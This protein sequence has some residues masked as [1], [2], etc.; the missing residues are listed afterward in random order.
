MAERRYGTGND[1]DP[2]GPRRGLSDYQRRDLM[3]QG[4]D[5]VASI[6]S[7]AG[8]GTVAFQQGPQIL[9]GLAG[10][11]GGGAGEPTTVHLTIFVP[12]R[13]RRFAEELHV[14]CRFQHGWKG[15]TGE[16]AELLDHAD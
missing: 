5:V 14:C 4:G 7:G 1:N 15:D 6:G 11:E 12:H 10:G 9:Q 3:Y 8:L 2:A 13:K 16:A